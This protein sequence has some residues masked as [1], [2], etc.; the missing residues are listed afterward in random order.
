MSLSV[1]LCQTRSDSNLLILESSS[2]NC[3][4]VYFFFCIL[5]TGTEPVC[6]VWTCSGLW[7][8]P[9][10]G[11]WWDGPAGSPCGTECSR[12]WK[13]QLIGEDHS[14]CSIQ[15]W[16]Q[17]FGQH[18]QHIWRS[19]LKTNSLLRVVLCVLKNNNC[20]AYDCCF[21]SFFFFLLF[22]FPFFFGLH[23]SFSWSSAD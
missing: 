12:P 20:Y 22:F 17:C 16:T 6:T 9:S 23:F 14:L 7:P 21:S 10:Q 19:V 18:E 1:S 8:F 4:P 11:I 2:S 13:V 5:F 15:K 3:L